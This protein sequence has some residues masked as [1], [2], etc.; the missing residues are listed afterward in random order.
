MSRLDSA[1]RRLQAQRLLLDQAA[2]DI[3]SMDGVVLELGLGNGR[4]YDHLRSIL[5]DRDIYVFER[6]VQAHPDCI[7]DDAHLFL[8]DVIEGLN[9]AQKTLSAKTVLVHADLGTGDSQASQDFAKNKL[10]AAIIPLLAAGAHVLCDQQLL[11]PGATK[12][13][14]PKEMDADR[15]HAYRMDDPKKALKPVLKAA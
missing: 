5:P 13:P 4:T 6:D 8:G 9:R 2:L 12:L 7:P 15:Y 1:I 3:G 11:L 14:L 10:S